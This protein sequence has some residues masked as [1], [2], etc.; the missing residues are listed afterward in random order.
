VHTVSFNLSFLE[1]TKEDLPGFLH[2][3]QFVFVEKGAV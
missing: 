2:T 3:F 1:E